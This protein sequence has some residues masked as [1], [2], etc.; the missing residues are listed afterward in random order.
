MLQ[1][2]VLRMMDDLDRNDINVI[3]LSG[4]IIAWFNMI[5]P[6]RIAQETGKPVI[7]VT[8]EESDGLLPEISV[9]I[10]PVMSNESPRTGTL[11]NAVRVDLHTKQTIFIRC[12]GIEDRRRNPSL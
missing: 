5:N 12:W 2:S 9:I 4:C 3:M 11:V 7:C 10:F 1:K 8:Y 6:A